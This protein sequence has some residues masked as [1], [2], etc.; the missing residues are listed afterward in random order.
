MRFQ[1]RDDMEPARGAWMH[2]IGEG[3]RF[4]QLLELSASDCIHAQGVEALSPCGGD[5]ARNV[6]HPPSSLQKRAPGRAHQLC[7]PGG[8]AERARWAADRP[9]LRDGTQQQQQQQQQR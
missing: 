9:R 1:A 4:P 5:S 3:Q 6:R 8:G 7:G 2:V